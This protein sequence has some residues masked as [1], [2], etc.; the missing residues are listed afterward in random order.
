[1]TDPLSYEPN[2]K[3]GQK[4]RPTPKGVS[5]PSPTNGQAALDNS[6]Q[7]KLT[8]PRRVGVDKVNG[9]IVVLDQHLP[10]RYHGHVRPWDDLT[11]KM[12][13]ALIDAGL[14]DKKGAIL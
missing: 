5:S 12:K 11:P 13:I 8:S 14:V 4:G 10:A 2:P 3:H 7:I 9:E 1:M 6:V